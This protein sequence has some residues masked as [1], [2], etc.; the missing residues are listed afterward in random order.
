MRDYGKRIFRKINTILDKHFVSIRKKGINNTDFTIISNNCWAG[1]IYRRFGL[2]YLTP[3]VGLYFFADD[4]LKLC[5]DIK[6]HMEMPL[7]FISADE[8]RHREEI[9]RK[10]QINVP[11]ARLG[12]IEVVFLHYATKD[13]AA[14]KWNR[15]V[16]RINYDNLIVK[17][18]KMNCCTDEHLK[19]FDQLIFRKKI[20][21]VPNG[22][23]TNIRCGIRFKS[24]VGREEIKDDTS[25]YSRYI[26]LKKMINSKRVCGQ[27]MEG[28]WVGK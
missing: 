22:D 13:E 3:T 27:Y 28:N 12:D 16:N 21:F 14:E 20:C 26:N 19:R 4:F 25:E 10:G 17:F 8:S 5:S 7:K 18:G 1:Y 9:V 6:G 23:D 2:P 11:I 24:A 15:R